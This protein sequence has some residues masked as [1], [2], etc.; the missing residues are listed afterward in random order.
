MKNV[1]LEHDLKGKPQ[2]PNFGAVT[3]DG[4]PAAEKLLPGLSDSE[5]EAIIQSWKSVAILRV[6]PNVP[7]RLGFMAA[8]HAEF[9]K[10][11]ITAVDGLLGVHIGPKD[12]TFLAIPDDHKTPTQLELVEVTALDDSKYPDLPLY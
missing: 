10:T 8:G 12:T 6:T 5:K 9:L 7:I 11:P 2:W 3:V 4:D 1:K